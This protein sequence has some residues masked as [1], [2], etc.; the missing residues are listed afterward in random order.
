MI[1]TLI[2]E[3]LIS[4]DSYKEHTL[5]ILPDVVGGREMSTRFLRSM[6]SSL[7]QKLVNDIMFHCLPSF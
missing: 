7:N 2:N 1:V 5:T 3:V 4:Y 6:H